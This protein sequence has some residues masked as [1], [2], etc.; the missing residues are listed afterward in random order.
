MAD[1]GKLQ[2]AL[3]QGAAGI[4]AGTLFAFCEESG[5]SEAV[6]VGVFEK[7]RKGILEVFTDPSASPT[8]FPFK[9]VGLEGTMSERDEYGA[10]SRICDLGYLR[11][12]YKRKDGSLG[13]RCPGEP[14]DTYLQK[15][16]RAEDTAGK[17]CICNGLMAAIGLGQTQKADYLERPL[18]TSGDDLS[19]IA[20]FQKGGQIRYSAS[21][22]IQ[23]L[24]GLLQPG[25]QPA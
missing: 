25:S 10:R 2:A 5:L 12:L 24:M 3:D 17:K 13:Y 4:Q 22:V 9:V 6:K 20:I 14:V 11:S 21:E 7:V 23:Y 1:P 18:I 15:E 8:G 16:G 19:R